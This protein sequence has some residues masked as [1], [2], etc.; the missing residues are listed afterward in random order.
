[1]A[2]TPS[3]KRRGMGPSRNQPHSPPFKGGVAA[4]RPGWLAR[5]CSRALLHARFRVRLTCR[6]GTLRSGIG[7]FF[8]NLS[9]RVVPEK[10]YPSPWTDRFQLKYANVFRELP[11]LL[12]LPKFKPSVVQSP[13][14]VLIVNCCLIGDFVVSLPAITDFIRE[15][16]NAQI[17]LLI[18]PSLV[19]LV[20]RLRCIHRVYSAQSVFRRGSE[21]H[22][23]D[24]KLA[25]SYDQVIVL[26]LSE[27]A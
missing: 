16:S 1:M 4:Q 8:L 25:S 6:C 23:S 15:H 14:T 22:G 26:R 24:E 18:S 3:L 9:S 21:L 20:R 2:Q 19:P 11:A 13:Q 10:Q 12:R 17:D 27:A 7:G 5:R